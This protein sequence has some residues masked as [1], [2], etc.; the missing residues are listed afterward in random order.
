MRDTE[1]VADNGALPTDVYDAG[2]RALLRCPDVPAHAHVT[3]QS[4]H[5]MVG[6]VAPWQAVRDALTVAYAADVKHGL[7]TA[8]L[9]TDHAIEERVGVEL[10][11]LLERLHTGEGMRTLGDL[12]DRHPQT[13]GLISTMPYVRRSE[14]AAIAEPVGK[15]LGVDNAS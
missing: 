1:G 4:L 8:E 5:R 15:L 10:D 6:E 3:M 13:E 2:V 7:D 11:T 14:L 9:L 12:L